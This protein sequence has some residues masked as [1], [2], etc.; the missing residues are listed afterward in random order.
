MTKQARWLVMERHIVNQ[1]QIPC[2]SRKFLQKDLQS[3]QSFHCL[4]IHGKGMHSKKVR[5]SPVKGQDR[6][7]T[8]VLPSPLIGA[9]FHRIAPR[10]SDPTEERA[11][12]TGRLFELVETQRDRTVLDRNVL[13]LKDRLQAR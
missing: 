8:R 2:S 6:R 3:R 10:C 1:L 11:K 4:R 13:L 7:L 9:T 12:M 5:Q